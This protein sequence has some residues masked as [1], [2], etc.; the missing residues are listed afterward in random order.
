[1]AWPEQNCPR[2]PVL[3][4][5]CAMK[6]ARDIDAEP[7][8][9]SSRDG[10]HCLFSWSLGL[11]IWADNK[12]TSCWMKFLYLRELGRGSLRMWLPGYQGSKFCWALLSGS[13]ATAWVPYPQHLLRQEQWPLPE[14]PSPTPALLMATAQGLTQ[15]CL[16]ATSIAACWTNT[17]FPTRICLFCLYDILIYFPYSV[18]YHIII[19]SYC[20]CFKFCHSRAWGTV[21]CCASITTVQLQGV[22]SPQKETCLKRTKSLSFLPWQPLMCFLSLSRYLLWTFLMNGIL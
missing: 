11:R 20:F 6:K 16:G 1:M 10:S 4:L 17:F 19:E 8:P 21:R 3:P 5:C 22:P 9:R 18:I 15:A 7:G 14:E 12:Q 13:E 2:L